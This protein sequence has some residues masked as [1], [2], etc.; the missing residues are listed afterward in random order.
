MYTR[1][2]EKYDSIGAD[3]FWVIVKFAFSGVV[4]DNDDEAL[5]GYIDGF[6]VG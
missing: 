3:T 6:D 5:V 1:K 2:F 4:G